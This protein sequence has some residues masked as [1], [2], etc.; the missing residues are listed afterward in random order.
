MGR[1]RDFSFTDADKLEQQVEVLSPSEQHRFMTRLA[2][3]THV[4]LE[5]FLQRED[6][7][8]RKLDEVHEHVGA[9]REE[10]KK[11]NEALFD[12]DNGLVYIKN[13]ICRLFKTGCWVVGGFFTLLASVAA[14]GHSFGFW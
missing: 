1:T 6:D 8:M 5:L 13:W 11:I 10:S 9:L 2:I 14:A 4:K 3:E 12:P 7:S